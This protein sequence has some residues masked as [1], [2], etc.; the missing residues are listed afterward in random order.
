MFLI[1]MKIML[2]KIKT[3]MQ[4]PLAFI[5]KVE[6]LISQEGLNVDKSNAIYFDMEKSFDVNKGLFK[7]CQYK[8]KLDS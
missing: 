2:W 6:H 1:Y 7:E 3:L 8:S 5:M 4:Q